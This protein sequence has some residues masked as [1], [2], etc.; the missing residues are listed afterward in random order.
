MALNWPELSVATEAKFWTDYFWLT[1]IDRQE[2]GYVSLVNHEEPVSDDTIRIFQY[3]R[4]SPPSSFQYCRLDIPLGKEKLRLQ[5]DPRFLEFNLSLCDSAENRAELA[6]DDQAAGH[7][8]VLRWGELDLICRC[9]ARLDTRFPHPG[10]PLLLLYRFAPLTMSEDCEWAIGLVR[11]AWIGLR[12]FTAEQI[13]QFIKLSD[14]REDGFEWRMDVE[15][16]WYLHQEEGVRYKRDLYTLRHP[17]NSAFP[18]A[19]LNAGLKAAQI[20]C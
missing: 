17:D 19:R 6:W 14:S 9:V 20:E 16:G 2:Q 7:P 18:F 8:D 11:R 5:F 3:H 15:K 4:L 1:S 10:L 13:D 12:L